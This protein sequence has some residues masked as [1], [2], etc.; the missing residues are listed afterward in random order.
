MRKP[1]ETMTDL[2]DQAGVAA[3]NDSA[4]IIFDSFVVYECWHAFHIQACQFY[5]CG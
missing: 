4:N 3:A 5:K 2:F 1:R